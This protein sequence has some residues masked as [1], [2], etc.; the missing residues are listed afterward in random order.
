MRVSVLLTTA[1]LCVSSPFAVGSVEAA[2]SEHL[3]V[4]ALVGEAGSQELAELK[5]HAFALRNRGTL[6]GVYG[7]HAKH[8]RFEPGW[9]FRR[10]KHAWLYAHSGAG[11]PIRGRTEWRSE[12][13]L[14]LM[15]RRGETPRSCGLYDPLKIG[16][17]T[18]Y[19]RTK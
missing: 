3:A 18:F 9:V 8:V 13:D 19:R 12:Y 17:T 5:A 1:F 2:I 7:L 4:R 11:D 15:A 14:K 16:E 10:A 6:R